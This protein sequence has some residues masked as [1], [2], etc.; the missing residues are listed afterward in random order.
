MKSYAKVGDWNVI[1]HVCRDKVKA[2]E[3]RKRW[4]GLIVCGRDGCFE[5]KHPLDQP[6]PVVKENKPLPFTSPEPTDTY[7]SLTLD[8]G[9]DQTG[10]LT[11][12]FNEESL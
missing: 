3:S 12:T 10:V 8:S 7:V 9:R 6:Q 5:E 4:D 11:G 2:S 1:C